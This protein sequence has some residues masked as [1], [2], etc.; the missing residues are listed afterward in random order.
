MAHAAPPTVW[1]SP[2]NILSTL[3]VLGTEKATNDTNFNYVPTLP[4]SPP[5]E[6]T[7]APSALMLSSSAREKLAKW[8]P[9]HI[10]NTE[11]WLLRIENGHC[12]TLGCTGRPQVHD[13]VEKGMVFSIT[14]RCAECGEEHQINNVDQWPEGKRTG[15]KHG[16]PMEKFNLETVTV[17]VLAGGTFESHRQSCMR[18][19]I[20]PLSQSAYRAAERWVEEAITKV[21]VKEEAA[22]IAK[23]RAGEWKMDHIGL[24][25]SWLT[26]R[27][28]AVG[29]YTATDVERGKIICEEVMTKR[30]THRINGKEVVITEGN[31]DGTSKGMEGE[32]C[33][34]LLDRLEQE[35]LLAKVKTITT[36]DDSSVVKMLAEDERLS[37]IKVMLPFLF[38]LAHTLTRMHMCVVV[39]K[40]RKADRG[41]YIKA[42]TKRLTAVLGKGKAWEGKAKKMASWLRLCR[43]AIIVHMLSCVCVYM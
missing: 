20:K 7:A 25:G 43:N 8:A 1:S 26:R 9:C 21:E 4:I 16:P 37:H 38:T 14:T 11:A 28:S 32:G 42:F 40:Q 3:S 17:E 27:D 2:S 31:Y 19:G 24:D 30:S 35:Q 33:R 36:D 12:Q 15:G 29:Y 13:G 22:N 10:I 5:S 39:G 41:H 23:Y 6:L 34:R 18:C